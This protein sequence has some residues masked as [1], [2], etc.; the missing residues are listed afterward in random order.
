MKICPQCGRSMER[1]IAA[2]KIVFRCVCGEE[3]DGEPSDV[4]ITGR[5][6][7]PGETAEKYQK[8]IRNSPYDRTN[9]QVR[10]DCTSCGL[11]YMTQIRVGPEEVIIYTCKCGFESSAAQTVV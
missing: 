8:L 4:R 3:T 11:D 10:R 2:D 7:H 9:Q 6:L 5:V 1:V